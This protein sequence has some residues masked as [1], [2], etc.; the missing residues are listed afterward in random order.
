[1]IIFG[2]Y[3]LNENVNN[4]IWMFN[5]DDLSWNLISPNDSQFP[6]PRYHHSSILWDNNKMVI[7]G[8]LST[9][10]QILNDTWIFNL[11]KFYF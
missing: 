3:D 8:G 1:M 2:G 10:S 4:D 7:F 6:S 11:G 5:F 9:N